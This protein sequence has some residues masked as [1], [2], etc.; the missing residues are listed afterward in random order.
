M[1][2]KCIALLALTCA[3]FSLLAWG[4]MGHRAVARIAE[5]HLTSK[6]KREIARLLGAE[7]LPLV[8]TWPDEIRSDPQYSST[9]PWHYLN[10]VP[11]LDFP[12]FAA[13][14][15]ATP[16]AAAPTNAYTALQQVRKDLRDP[17]KTAAEKLFALKF[18]VHLVGDVHQPLHVGRG[19]DRGG[20][21]IQV[22]WRGRDSNLHSIWDGDLV[23][24]PGFTY[25]EMA[26]AYDHATSAQVK[27]W[28][29]DDVATWLFESY[30]LCTPVYAAA[31]TSPKF[32][33]RFYPSFGPAVQQQILKAGIRLAGVLNEVYKK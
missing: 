8:S 31:A 1:F 29:K 22:N 6:A 32:D 15:N 3:P 12:A 19:E 17:A 5:N 24:Y 4:T 13:Q 18:V 9:G 26:A 33:Y 10:V 16:A 7:T 2:R 25:S 27:Q 20:N 21:S 14:L 30:Q 28:Q 23:E 11:G